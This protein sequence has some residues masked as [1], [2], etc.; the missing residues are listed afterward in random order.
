MENFCLDT[1]MITKWLVAMEQ[2]SLGEECLVFV[3][4]SDANNLMG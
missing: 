3:L 4:I 2:D 1:L